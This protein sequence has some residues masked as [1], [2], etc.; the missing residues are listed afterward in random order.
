M[1]LK[2]LNTSCPKA[3]K[4]E[5]PLLPAREL[6][7]LVELLSEADDALWASR[8]ESAFCAPEMLLFERSVDTFDKNFPSGLL[9]SAFEGASCCTWL[10]YFSASVVSP[11]LIADIRLDSAAPNV[12]CELEVL[13]AWV[14]EDEDRAVKSVLV[15]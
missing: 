13:E 11:D 3:L 9:G 5:L 7:E 8:V 4:A 6:A 10:K 15:L 12:F 2:R 14:V 1:A